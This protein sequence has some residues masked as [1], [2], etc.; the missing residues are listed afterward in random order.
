MALVGDVDLA[1]LVA[2]TASTQ[3]LKKG[4]VVDVFIDSPGGGSK[5]GTDIADRITSLRL[6]G[7][8]F[9]CQALRAV[10]AA[11]MIWSVCSEREILAYGRALFHYPYAIV[12]GGLTWDTAA[13]IAKDLKEQRED[14]RAR[15]VAALAPVKP[16]DIDAA[17]AEDRVFFGKEFCLTFAPG[18]CKVVYKLPYLEEKMK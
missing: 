8:V 12:H 13:E 4:D 7:V 18:F 1:M 6:S 14:Y 5:I 15:L 9:R 2:F 16:E 10:S 11:F 17:A 3:G